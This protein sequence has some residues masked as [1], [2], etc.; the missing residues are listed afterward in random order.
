M[1][2]L[3]VGEALIDIVRDASGGETARPG[4]SPFNIAVGLARLET[5]ATL[6]AQI[7]GDPHGQMLRDVLAASGAALTA[8]PPSPPRTATAIATIAA[9]G[10]ASYA[11]DLTW[12]PDHLP[13]PSGFDAVHVGSIGTVLQPG[14][15]VVAAWVAE[16]SAAGAVVSFDPNVRL[17]VLDDAA[18][19]RRRFDQ[20]A[21]YCSLLK[22]SDE[23]ASVLFGAEP[24]DEIAAR[25]AASGTI[26]AI[27]LGADGAVVAHG[28]HLVRVP[29][30]AIRVV[31][32]IGAGDTFMA[33]I[34]AT[35]LAFDRP[36]DAPWSDEELTTLAHTAVTAAAIN[37]S[38][39]GADPPTRADLTAALGT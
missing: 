1:N 31:D 33:A 24:P 39:E 22:M 20:I 29:A 32:T 28:G 38:R 27:T 16:A 7:G 2:V 15:D 9:D 19:F 3:V 10:S 6:A 13:D 35:A 5:P 23:D 4:G 8:L 25:L 26:A 34:L 12:N 36:F 14:A 17:S 11:F 18:E 21:P 30:P 37:C